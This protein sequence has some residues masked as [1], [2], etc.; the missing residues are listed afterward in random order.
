MKNLHWLGVLVVS[1]PLILAGCG[2]GDQKAS[3]DKD[4]PIRGKVMAVN[5]DKPTVKLDHEDI[6][7]YMKG[8]QMDFD[9]EDRKM[10]EGV[11][12]GDQVEGR[13][14]VREGKATISR[15]EKKKG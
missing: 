11:Q 3:E 9:V 14:K 4:Y 8:M 15:L 2:G 12:P 1:A 13:L 5:P 6:P 10:L 7:G